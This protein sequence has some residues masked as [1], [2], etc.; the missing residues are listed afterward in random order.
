VRTRA[1]QAAEHTEEILLRFGSTCAD[2]K[3]LTDR[4]VIS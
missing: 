2:L 4:G 1:P 3:S